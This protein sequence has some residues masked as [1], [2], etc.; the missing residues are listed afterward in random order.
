MAL[1]EKQIIEGFW[2]GDPA[3]NWPPEP[4]TNIEDNS[5]GER[6]NLNITQ[7][8]V[9][10]YQQRKIVDQWCREL[11]GLREVKYLW[12]SSRVSQKM[13]E[14]ACRMPNLEGL[15]IKWSGIK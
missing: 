8:D 10:D 6:L 11:P 9:N 13:F 2:Y 5:P 14:A 12:F 3:S 4:V 15:N 1:T 7:L